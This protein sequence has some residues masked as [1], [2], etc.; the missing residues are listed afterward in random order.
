MD[1]LC[2]KHDLSI[3]EVLKQKKAR[4]EKRMIIGID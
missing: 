3:E 4:D 1:Y 2:S